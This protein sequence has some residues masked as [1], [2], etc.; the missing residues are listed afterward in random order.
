VLIG[1]GAVA[2]VLPVWLLLAPRDYLPPSSRSAPSC[3]G[4]GHPHHRPPLKMP[5][6]TACRSGGP[7]WA[8]GLFPSCS[9]PS[10]AG[11]FGFHALIQRHHPKLIA[12]E[13]DAPIIGYGA[14]LMEA[15]VAIM[16]LVGPRSLIRASICHE[17]PCRG[18]GQ[19]NGQRGAGC[20][21]HGLCHHARNAGRRRAR[22]GRKDHH[23]PRRR[24]P[25][26]AVGMAEIF[27]H[28]FGGRR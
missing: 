17:Q 26:L 23:Q 6:L 12:S 8:G 16:A 11:G 24:R 21:R 22:S 25:T 13:A 18:G 5:A 27:S 3:A 4:A 2:S 7:V 20:Q 28:V 9:S 1:Y 10:P 14:M 15:F 19:G